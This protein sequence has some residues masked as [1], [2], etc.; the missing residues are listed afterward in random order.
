MYLMRVILLAVL[1]IVMFVEAA[2]RHC[3]CGHKKKS[4][5]THEDPRTPVRS[6]TKLKFKIGRNT[7]I[8]YGGKNQ[9][10]I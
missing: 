7:R 6:D 3:E 4:I 10:Y 5:D 9:K 1:Y 8:K 2:P